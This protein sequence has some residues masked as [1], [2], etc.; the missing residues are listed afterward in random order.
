METNPKSIFIVIQNETKTIS[1]NN[2]C[3]YLIK[4]KQVWHRGVMGLWIRYWT[5][6]YK[7]YWVQS[8][9]YSLAS[10]ITGLK[11][12]HKSHKLRSQSQCYHYIVH[13]V[14][15]QNFI[16]FPDMEILWKLAV[17]A[18]FLAIRPKLCVSTKFR[19]QETS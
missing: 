10:V 5:H 3:I 17:S 1:K 9:W 18:E 6:I 14:K 12:Q 16:K 4:D 7:G 19:H 15:C 8:V 13:R 2:S 11:V